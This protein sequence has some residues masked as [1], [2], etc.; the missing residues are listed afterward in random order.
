MLVFVLFLI[1]LLFCVWYFK[2]NKTNA[3]ILIVIISDQKLYIYI[4]I[5]VV[6]RKVVMPWNGVKSQKH[7]IVS[8]RCAR[9]ENIMKTS[10]N[11]MFWSRSQKMYFPLYR[12][13]CKIT[14]HRI[15]SQN[16]RMTK[17]SRK[18]YEMSCFEDDQE[19]GFRW[20]FWWSIVLGCF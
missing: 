4:Y 8:K 16:V 14:K 6:Y 19:F 20:W 10:R 15:V 18:R 13:M 3:R 2:M 11:V 7:R 12:F 1:L 9:D 17:T 5:S